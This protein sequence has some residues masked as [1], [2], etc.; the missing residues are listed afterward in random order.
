M[1]AGGITA[2][3]LTA[4]GKPKLGAAGSKLGSAGKLGA[5]SGALTAGPAAGAKSTNMG[6]YDPDNM[7]FPLSTAAVADVGINIPAVLPQAFAALGTPQAPQPLAP[8]NDPSILEKTDMGMLPMVS[9]T[10]T[11][12]W[13]TYARPF[14][15]DVAAPML[16]L[17]VTGLGMSASLT[18][19]AINHLPVEVT[20]SFSAYGSSVKSW[21]EKARAVGHEVLLEVPMETDSFPVDDP[22]P[23]AM[24]TTKK[25]SENLKLLNLLMAQAQGYVGF[26]GQFGSKFTKNEKKMSPILGELKSRGLFFVDPRSVEGSIVLETADQMQLPRAI[27]DT[28][29]NSNVSE[30]Q[31]RAQLETL[32][33]VTGN[34]G[35]SIG[36]IHATP[37]FIKAIKEWAS[38][39]Q[40]IQLAPVTS[41][42]GRQQS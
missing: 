19:A 5:A 8:P 15:G 30:N 13:K 2:G 39:V 6:G 1:T 12:P 29:L 26:I 32:S 25:T 3:K 41:L 20:L 14:N 34:R 36:A 42:A 9:E 7:E 23:M 33:T 16:G 27:I 40:G 24:M 22:G 11:E 17:V 10:G 4:G 35:V 31:I 18:E 38:K 37:F 28:T 21:V